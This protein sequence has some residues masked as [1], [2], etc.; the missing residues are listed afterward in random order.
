MVDLR[1]GIAKLEMKSEEGGVLERADDSE[2]VSAVGN[3]CL[4]W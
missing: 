3:P 4:G 1:V 2:F